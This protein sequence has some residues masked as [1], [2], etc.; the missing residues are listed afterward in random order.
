MA[1]FN[2]EKANQRSREWNR[3]KGGDPG[4]GKPVAENRTVQRDPVPR[5]ATPLE[6]VQS[7]RAA[8]PDLGKGET[9]VTLTRIP[10]STTLDEAALAHRQ[11]TYGI[12]LNE[13]WV[14]QPL[15]YRRP[16]QVEPVQP[17]ARRMRSISGR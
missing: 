8:D 17:P 6:Q 14:G 12:G 5:S 1:K 11:K 2:W 16:A 13:S 4:S 15:V 9:N 3:R 7:A 10:P